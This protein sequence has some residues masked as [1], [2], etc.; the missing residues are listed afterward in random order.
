MR[1]RRDG[2]LTEGGSGWLTAV[3]SPKLP[4]MGRLLDTVEVSDSSS[5]GPTM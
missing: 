3:C 5:L 4:S 2:L 1:H